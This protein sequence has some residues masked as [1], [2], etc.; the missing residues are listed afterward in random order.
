MS[1]LFTQLADDDLHQI[2]AAL[3]GG[4]LAAPF[5]AIGLQRLVNGPVASAIAGELQRLS[6]LSFT[7]E[8]LAVMIELIIEDRARRS[9]QDG[10][11]DLVTTGPDVAGVTNR[12]TSVVVRELFA[13]ATKSVLVAGF[14]VYQGRHVFRALADR[15]Q[16]RPGIEVRLFLDVQRGRGDTTV[17]SSLVRRFAARFKTDQWPS[18]RPLPQVFFD[19]RSVELKAEQHAC[20]HAKCIVVDGEAVFV[21]SANFTEAAQERNIEVGLL[22]RSHPLAEQLT[23]HFDTLLAAGMLKPVW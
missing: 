12:D 11:I 21:S 5:T 14:A 10:S 9:K 13:R 7:G 17:A 16:E 2:A 15:M 23:R 20:L 22:V 4:R 8:Q 18:E 1:S 19:P 3:R 6:E